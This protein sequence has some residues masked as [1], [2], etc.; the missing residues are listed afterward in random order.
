[1]SGQQLRLLGRDARKAFARDL[2]QAGGI[3]HPDVPVAVSDQTRLLQL[4]CGR[5]H[6]GPAH[7]QHHREEL[8]CQRQVV[9]ADP[10]TRQQQPTRAALLQAVS[11]VAGGG[12]QDLLVKAVRVTAKMSPQRLV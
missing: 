12:L 1:M 7:R 9:G 8:L 11:A 3:E 4:A 6:P 5:G 2:F 10:M